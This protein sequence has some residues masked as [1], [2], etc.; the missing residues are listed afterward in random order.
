[1]C[2]LMGSDVGSSEPDAFIRMSV[3]MWFIYQAL[4]MRGDVWLFQVSGISILLVDRIIELNRAGNHLNAGKNEAH[5]DSDQMFDQIN[6]IR[7][8]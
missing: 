8:T 3:L 2:S 7:T 1:M 4:V 5:V 6:G